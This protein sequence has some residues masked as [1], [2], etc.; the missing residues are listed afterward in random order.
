MKRSRKTVGI[1]LSTFF[2]L[3]SLLTSMAFAEN[4][5][6]NKDVVA[7]ASENKSVVNMNVGSGD[8]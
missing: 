2:L 8:S 5:F 7:T 4:A 3:T 1:I 6:G